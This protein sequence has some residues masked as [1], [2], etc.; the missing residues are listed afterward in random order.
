LGHYRARLARLTQTGTPD[1]VGSARHD[2]ELEHVS[3]YVE[4]LVSNAPP[5][6]SCQRDRLAGLLSRA[7][8]A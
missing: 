1:E 3:R 6:T 4:K 8:A 5:L 7:G 2:L